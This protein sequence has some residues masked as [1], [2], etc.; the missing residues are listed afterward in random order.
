ME[1]LTVNL[2]NNIR[3]VI[4]L[5]LK[6]G[7]TIPVRISNVDITNNTVKFLYGD[8]LSELI[9]AQANKLPK[10]DILKNEANYFTIDINEIERII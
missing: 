5:V 7:K 9:E 4:R 8:G 10:E 3:K 1:Q 2:Q 6:S